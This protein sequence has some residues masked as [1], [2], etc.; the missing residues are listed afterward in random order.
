MKTEDRRR[1]KGNGGKSVSL[2]LRAPSSVIQTRT[3]TDSLGPIDVPAESCWGAQ[4]ERS[5]HNFA[6]GEQLIPR[7][8]VAALALVKRAAEA[9]GWPELP[10]LADD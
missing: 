8:L 10:P 9:Y 4:N 3:E 2:A 6:I 5:R 7:P 1:R